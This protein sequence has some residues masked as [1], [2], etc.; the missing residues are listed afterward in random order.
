MAST[1]SE[2]EKRAVT[3]MVELMESGKES[4]EIELSILEAL[5]RLGRS[6]EIPCF[7]LIG[8]LKDEDRQIRL[9]AVES[10]G[11]ARCREALPALVQLLKDDKSKY[12]V[13]WA[14]GELGDTRAIPAL[15]PLLESDDQYA[16]Y[17]ARRAL[18]K[19]GTN[20]VEATSTTRGALDFSRIAFE[21]YQGIM[22][23]LF[24]RIRGLKSTWLAR[25]AFG[26]CQ[27]DVD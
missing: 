3:I 19:I 8:K 11:K 21:K 10:L 17:N 13:I 16:R 15:N 24:K 4:K 9:Q 20:K 25:P 22:L 1:A 2:R 26:L 27:L 7:P 18:A 5:G 12:C 14:L 23:S 6:T